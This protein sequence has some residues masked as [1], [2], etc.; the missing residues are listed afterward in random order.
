MNQLTLQQE[1]AL[2][3][4]AVISLVGKDPE[5]EYRP[6]FVESTFA[7]LRRKSTKHFISAQ[8]FLANVARESQ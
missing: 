8:Q 4:S 6:D 1:V 5:G 3:R 2:L 7:A